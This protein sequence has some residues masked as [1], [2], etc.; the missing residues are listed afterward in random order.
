MD[1]EKIVHFGRVHFH[2]DNRKFGIKD[3]DRLLHV[4]MIGKTGT[5]KS[6]MPRGFV[7]LSLLC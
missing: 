7:L 4:Y 6:S 1:E 2:N 3:E 5:G